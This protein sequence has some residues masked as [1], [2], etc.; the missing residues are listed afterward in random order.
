LF[1]YN[2]LLLLKIEFFINFQSH[3]DAGF[4]PLTISTK[5][6]Y[7]QWNFNYLSECKIN[8]PDHSPVRRIW[9]MVGH[10]RVTIIFGTMKTMMKIFKK[11]YKTRF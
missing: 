4:N 10:F 8:H 1:F 3:V 2:I 7:S 6:M 11:K 5:M 9:G